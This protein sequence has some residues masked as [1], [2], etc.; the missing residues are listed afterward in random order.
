MSESGRTRRWAG[1]AGG[2]WGAALHELVCWAA[3]PLAPARALQ[4]ALL[5]QLYC[6]PLPLVTPPDPHAMRKVSRRTLE[7]DV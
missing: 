5:R 6:T 1:G 2:E 3:A 7:R 4:P